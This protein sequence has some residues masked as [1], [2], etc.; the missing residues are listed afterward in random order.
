MR[1]LLSWIGRPSARAPRGEV[2]APARA[3]RAARRRE[4]VIMRGSGE[5]LL[6]KWARLVMRVI[7]NIGSQDTWSHRAQA[8]HC[9]S[10]SPDVDQENERPRPYKMI[11]INRLDPS[12]RRLHVVGD[13]ALQ[14][15]EG[16]LRVAEK[17][18]VVDA[19]A[20]GARERLLVGGYRLRREHPHA[21]AQLR[22]VR[23]LML[24]VE[25]G[26]QRRVE[27]LRAELVVEAP[28]AEAGGDRPSVVP[29][30]DRAQ[31][32]T[33]GGEEHL[34]LVIEVPLQRRVV[35]LR[36]IERERTEPLAVDLAEVVLRLRGEVVVEPLVLARGAEG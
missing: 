14:P 12:H 21:T 29:H 28:D 22:A 20:G 16:S 5:R 2:M 36:R 3:R 30:P 1:K 26:R 8:T 18:Q 11:G 17:S 9:E 4:E 10:L 15:L 34:G 23:R 24:V 27:Q 32:V 6:G 33:L 7:L 31:V 19:G 25:P 35:P 13:R